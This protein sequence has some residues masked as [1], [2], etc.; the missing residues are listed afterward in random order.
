MVSV[1]VPIYNTKRSYLRACIRSVQKQSLAQWRL[2][3]VDDGSTN[4]AGKLCDR[5]AARDS[6][7]TVVHQENAGN[8]AARN[9][10]IAEC[11][12][13]GGSADT[14]W[15]MFL[16]SDDLLHPD[17]LRIT[18]QAAERAQAD[19][20]V[21]QNTRRILGKTIDTYTGITQ[22]RVYE[23]DEI[24][25]ELYPAY[26]GIQ[27][28]SGSMCIKLY[29]LWLV[30]QVPEIPKKIVFFEEDHY[31]NLQLL[32][33]V[34]RL[35]YLP[36]KLYSYRFGG[37]SSRFI[38]SFL[39]DCLAIHETQA[40]MAAKVQM[41]I[42]AEYYTAVE[43]KNCLYSWLCSCREKGGY[44]DDAL[45]AEMLRC[46]A[47]PQI[48]RALRHPKP[49]HSGRP[50]FREALVEERWEDALALV[51]DQ[52]KKP[53]KRRVLDWLLKVIS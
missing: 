33:Q 16:D 34:N 35:V 2:V 27:G 18:T 50:G 8:F 14:D 29:P 44:S 4:G 22:A 53:W 6:R 30:R 49:D 21:F 9:R 32:P 38:S 37:G 47:I 24:L 31:V 5:F 20:V 26:F 39:A 12:A 40:T 7:V 15:V 23:R 43:L 48:H 25:R 52:P 46:C 28:F 10:G 11:V 42:D 13:R 19:M 45:R 17:A 51:C 3:L 41:P 1:V 36:D